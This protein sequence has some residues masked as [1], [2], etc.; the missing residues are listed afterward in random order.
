MK[1]KTTIFKSIAFTA[2]MA[3]SAF[4]TMA[5]APEA[6]NYQAVIRNASGDL[7]MG[8]VVGMRFTVN[9]GSATGTTVY[10][11]T[12][13]LTP[14]SYGLVKHVIGTG[15]VTTGNFEN[16]DWGGASMFLKVEAD[17]NGGTNYANLGT[18]KFQSVPYALE[19]KHAS[20]ASHAA[21]ADW[22][23]SLSSLELR[24][25]PTPFLDFA[26]DNTT[27]YDM[28]LILINDD[29]LMIDGGQLVVN[30]SVSYSAF[31]FAYLQN[32]SPITGQ[33]TNTQEVSID[34]SNIV[35][36]V[37]YVAVS[38]GRIKDIEQRSD[39][40]NDLAI[41]NQL[42]VTDYKYKD[43]VANGHG[44]TKGFIAQEVEQLIPE[45]ITITSDFIPNIYE[46]AQE[47]VAA[48]NGMSIK[49]KNA[50]QLKEG[51]EVRLVADGRADCMVDEVIDENTF[52]VCGL[53]ENA[54]QVFVYG[55]KVDDFHA[56]D[57]DRIFVSGIGAIQALSKQVEEL[58]QVNETLMAAYANLEQHN[59]TI[60]A[61]YATIMDDIRFIKEA[62]YGLGYSGK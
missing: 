17:P 1:T 52:T 23:G 47:V 30:G 55:K 49:L 20:T 39:I 35:K 50:H 56:V 32:A 3:V 45:A 38:D 18:N 36:A 16:I 11:E 10:Q 61:E 4:T 12:K 42:Q 37:A 28:R 21:S 41:V 9:S 31:Q 27:D 15:T 34:A 33:A 40:E 13:N 48:P 19:A 59:N 53:P 60:M 57:Y 58:K 2:L 26:N 54:E 8:G 22:V 7:V 44:T 46:M 5:Q 51:D 25:G 24:P 62:K 29:Q 6:F 14:N 43:V